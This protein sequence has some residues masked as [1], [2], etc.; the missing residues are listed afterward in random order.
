MT[1]E[2]DTYRCDIALIGVSG[3]GKS[4]LFNALTGRKDSRRM[5]RFAGLKG[6]SLVI[7]DLA[8][9]TP[10]VRLLAYAGQCERLL[11]VIPLKP[12][13]GGTYTHPGKRTAAGFPQLLEAIACWNRDFAAKERL[14]VLNCFP[15]VEEGETETV[16]STLRYAGETVFIVNAASGEE[17]EFLTE[18]INRNIKI[19]E[20]ALYG[21]QS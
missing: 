3:T 6:S 9:V 15:G 12:G 2:T 11:F 18:G 4:T 19:T 13:K 7:T 16:I 8:G 14:V 20:G 17:V 10:G 5:P 1:V 21:L